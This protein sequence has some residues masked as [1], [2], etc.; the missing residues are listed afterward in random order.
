MLGRVLK[1]FGLRP[2]FQS[3]SPQKGIS[4]MKNVRLYAL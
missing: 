4:T 1:R 3:L 2:V